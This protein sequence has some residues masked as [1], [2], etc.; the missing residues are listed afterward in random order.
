M[1]E[2]I[3]MFYSSSKKNPTHTSNSREHLRDNFY[4]T[5]CPTIETLEIDRI[6]VY[7]LC[8]GALTTSDLEFERVVMEM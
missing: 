4:G 5:R 8:I 1:I 3:K 2:K 7:V 6:K